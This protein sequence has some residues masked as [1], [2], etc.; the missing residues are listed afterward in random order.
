VSPTCQ[1]CGADIA[2]DDRFCRT[3]GTALTIRCRECGA[4][5][6]SGAE[7]CG[8]CGT[9]VQAIALRPIEHRLVT[10]LYV[11]LVEST[12]LAERSTRRT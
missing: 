8:E 5:L 1:S 9:P 4:A 10:A 3:C 12:S 6:R 2:A 7:F 11:D